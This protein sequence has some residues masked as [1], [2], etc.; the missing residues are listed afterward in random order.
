[1]RTQEILTTDNEQFSSCLDNEILVIREKRHI[2]H[3]TQ[4]AVSIFSLYDYMESVLSSNAY[5]ALVMFARSEQ[6]LYAE[7][8][9]FLS[10]ILSGLLEDH[11]LDRFLNVVNQF[12][13]SIPT[14]NCM[15]VFAGQGTISLFY[16]STG[17]AYDYRI[18]AE[19]TVFENPNLDIGLVT[20]GT[21]YF[22]PRLLGIRKATEVLQWKRFS[23]EDA[24]RLGLVDRIVPASRLEEETMR[25]VSGNDAHL[26]S[27]LLGIRKLFKCDIKE[28]R[29][30]L[31]LEDDLI[32]ERLKSEELRRKFTADL[33]NSVS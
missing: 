4:D 32:K 6:D 30:S 17:L 33:G 3:L 29:R 22:L 14:L 12:I 25:L 19:D 2:F 24:F 27:T 7:H 13:L 20:K 10:R 8:S 23:A 18:I 11:C 28:L 5:K 31:E 1:M 26:Y 9:R 15:T 21:G 16:L